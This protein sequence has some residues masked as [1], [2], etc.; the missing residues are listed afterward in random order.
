M[1]SLLLA[2]FWLLSSFVLFAQNDPCANIKDASNLPYLYSGSTC[3]NIVINNFCGYTGYT[4]KG[5]VFK[6]TVPSGVSCIDI[7]LRDITGNLDYFDLFVLDGCPTT[8]PS[9]SCVWEDSHAVNEFPRP[10]EHITQNVQLVSG[11]TYYIAIVGKRYATGGS[12]GPGSIDCGD[13]TIEIL[14]DTDCAMYTD[15]CAMEEIN[16]LPFTSTANT[17]DGRPMSSGAKGTCFDALNGTDYVYHYRNDNESVCA[18]ITMESAHTGMILSVQKS[19]RTNP[20]PQEC[21]GDFVFNMTESAGLTLEQG[22]DYYFY[23]SNLVLP[24]YCADFEMNITA[25][26]VTPVSCAQAIEVLNFD[27]DFDFN[28][29][30]C[31]SYTPGMDGSNCNS[32]DNYNIYSITIDEPSCLNVEY[33]NLNT[34]GDDFDIELYDD[35]PELASANCVA[36]NNKIFLYRTPTQ[37]T[38]LHKIPMETPGTYY[39]V[40]SSNFESAEY[41]I[42]LSRET[43]NFDIGTCDTPYEQPGVAHFQEDIWID[44]CHQINIEDSYW[45]SVNCGY[46]GAHKGQSKIIRYTAPEDNCYLFHLKGGSNILGSTLLSDCPTQ[47][48]PPCLASSVCTQKCDSVSLSVPLT[49]GQTVYW[50]VS[51]YEKLQTSEILSAEIKPLSADPCYDCEELLCRNCSYISTETGNIEG[52]ETYYGTFDNPGETN[53]LLGNAIN[54]GKNGRH[55]VMSAGSYDPYIPTLPVNNP[56]LG[57]YSIRI[58]NDGAQAKGEKMTYTY[59]IDSNSTFFTYYY[60]V[61]FEDPGHSVENQPYFRVRV[62]TEGGNEIQCGVYEV[63]AGGGIPGFKTAPVRPYPLYKEWTAVSIPV[64]DYVGQDLTVEFITRDCAEGDHFGYAYFDATCQNLGNLSD[65]VI[66]CGED[67]VE[68]IAPPGFEYYTWNTGETTP[69]IW[70]SQPGNFHVDMETHTG[71]QYEQDAVVVKIPDP[72]DLGVTVDQPCGDDKLHLQISNPISNIPPEHDLFWVINQTDT[73]RDSLDWY[74]SGTYGRYEFELFYIVPD[75]CDFTWSDSVYFVPP[76]GTTPTLPDTIFCQA[77]SVRMEVPFVDMM[78]YTWSNGD[79]LNFTHY[80]QTGDQYVLRDLGDCHDSIPFNVGVQAIIPIDLGA[81]VTICWYDSLKIGVTPQPNTTYTWSSGETT[82]EIWA[83]DSTKYVLVSDAQG[84]QAKDSINISFSRQANVELPPDTAICDGDAIRIGFSDVKPHV[85]NTGATSDSITASNQDWYVLTL[86]DGQ[87]VEKDSL[88]LTLLTPPQFSLGPDLDICENDSVLL[89][90][91]TFN[92]STHS[93]TW[94]TGATSQQIWA[95]IPSEYILTIS[96]GTCQNADSIQISNSVYPSFSLVNDT[97]YCQDSSVTLYLDNALG[98]VSWNNG[99]TTT[100]ITITSPGIYYVDVVNGSCLATDTVEVFEQV[101]PTLFVGNDTLLCGDELLQIEPEYQNVIN[102]Y[103]SWGDGEPELNRW[104]TT[105][106]GLYVL[107]LTDGFCFVQ[108]SI[109]VTYI[110]RPKPV[111]ENPIEVCLGDS[112]LLEPKTDPVFAHQWSTGENSPNIWVKNPG[113]YKVYV[114]L[115]SCLDSAATEVVNR[116]PPIIDLGPDTTVCLG[117]EIILGDTVDGATEYY[118]GNG[119]QGNLIEARLDGEF[120]LFAVAGSCVVSDTVEVELKDLPQVS[121]DEFTPKICPKD[122]ALIV[123]QCWNC[124]FDTPTATD[125]FTAWMEPLET[126]QVSA[127]TPFE[128]EKTFEYSTDQDDKC[129]EPIYVPNAF[130]PNGDAKNPSFHPVVVDES[131]Q[132][133]RFEITNR[134]GELIYSSENAPFVWDGTYKNHQV[135]MGVYQWQLWY[136]DVYQHNHHVRGHVTVIY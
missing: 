21:L 104:I 7:R 22:E 38:Y 115:N 100:N 126:I 43:A 81:D 26:P 35:C 134:W 32:G 127:V 76:L 3:G 125:R 67:S 94:N 103:F 5:D 97:M 86:D 108:D 14:N 39:L 53:S 8:D 122:S 110:D 98:A 28:D 75:K 31:R 82:S 101:K 91:N 87:C 84:C 95:N 36:P 49:A 30:K 112:V 77:D 51:A 106:G 50:V 27:T 78:R 74:Y 45:R 33:V 133:L 119:Y 16:A 118:W 113:V 130:S 66:I 83:A 111:L 85:W 93:F 117:S 73:V 37:D 129:I 120:I 99:V 42:D 123:L 46:S 132:I 68:L 124:V 62:L 70:T 136:Q 58:G 29:Y 24:G 9:A 17:C 40:V 2:L 4:G 61:V 18:T 109:E 88:Y 72:I 114:S 69:T 11:N 23:V 34:P 19:C 131:V 80:Q 52:W 71:C 79:S 63:S 10:Y 107:S 47:S 59:S 96:D 102:P 128:C 41:K 15:I 48:S 12:E 135:Q 105:P 6:V 116:T 65:E 121:L 13:F 92:P 1:R 44:P 60:A 25:S 20:V 57:R 89:G 90:P 64:I 56:F 54:S 55:N